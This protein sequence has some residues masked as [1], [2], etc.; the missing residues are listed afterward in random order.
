M[1]SDQEHI[2]SLELFRKL[3]KDGC[4]WHGDV[5]SRKWLEVLYIPDDLVMERV[6]ITL[7]LYGDA[8][9]RRDGYE[10]WIA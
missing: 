1:K 3:I 6:R 9:Y 10:V 8:D 7:T 5:M 2:R 4:E